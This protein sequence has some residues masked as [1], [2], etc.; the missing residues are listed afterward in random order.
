[1]LIIKVIGL[2]NSNMT[3]R[4]VIIISIVS[5]FFG[6]IQGQDIESPSEST[7]L[8]SICLVNNSLYREYYKQKN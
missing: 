2:T 1:M 6:E 3:R 4:K 5:L 7:D 8:D